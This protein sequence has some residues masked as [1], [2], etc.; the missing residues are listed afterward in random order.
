MLKINKITGM[1]PYGE[2]L[3]NKPLTE[4]KILGMSDKPINNGV[5]STK[6]LHDACVVSMDDMYAYV[7]T[8]ILGFMLM[9]M[10]D[11]TPKNITI[12]TPDNYE[13]PEQLLLLA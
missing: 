9:S 13:I 11:N 8:K 5:I 4:C 3:N 6:K 1:L 7:P 12:Y 10:N 2:N